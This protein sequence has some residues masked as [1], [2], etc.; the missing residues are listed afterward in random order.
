MIHTVKSFLTLSVVFVIWFVPSNSHPVR[1]G[2]LAQQVITRL[3]G[4]SVKLVVSDLQ[5]D[6]VHLEF[7]YVVPSLRGL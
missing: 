3:A 4:V 1:Q 7:L 2:N 6:A 5:S